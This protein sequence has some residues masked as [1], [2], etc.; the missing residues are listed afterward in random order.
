LSAGFC[1][2]FLGLVLAGLDGAGTDKIILTA[3]SNLTPCNLK[4]FA[5]SGMANLLY[6]AAL[7]HFAFRINSKKSKWIYPC[8]GVFNL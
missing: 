5:G 3:S 4:S 1:G 8:K 6:L 2:V 7:Y